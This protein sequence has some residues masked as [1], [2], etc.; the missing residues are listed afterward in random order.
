M[1]VPSSYNGKSAYP[2]TV[3]ELGEYGNVYFN[4]I[5]IILVLISAYCLYSLWRK[6]IELK[7]K[8]IWSILLLVP[9][10]GP[11]LYGYC[12]DNK[13]LNQK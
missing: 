12:I 2:V 13:T 8:L 10:L 3:E 7:R 11:L 4:T 5:L 1:N 9:L 6:Q